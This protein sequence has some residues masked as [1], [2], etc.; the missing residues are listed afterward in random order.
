MT[1]VEGQAASP[2]GE[3]GLS[4][5]WNGDA[6]TIAVIAVII[7]NILFV[8][9]SPWFLLRRMLSP[10]V[11]VA[12]MMIA[13]IVPLPLALLLLGLATAMDVFFI[14]AFLFDMPI[15]TTFRALFYAGDIDIQVSA[16]YAAAG[17]YFILLAFGLTFLARRFRLPL[18]R[19]SPVLACCI[20][21]LIGVVDFNMN[22]YKPLSFPAFESAM[23][24][25]SLTA[26]N[27][28]ARDR[29]LLVVIVE[30]MGAFADPRE[31]SL[32]SDRLAAAAAGRFRLASGTS[33]Y[34]GSTTGAEARELCGVW[35]TY[36]EFGRGEIRDCLPEK[37]ARGGY[38]TVSY[39]ASGSALFSRRDWYPRVGIQAMNFQED[40]ERDR[41]QAIKGRCGSVFFGICDSDVGDL[42]RDDLLNAGDRRGF[43]YWLTLNSHIPY[44]PVA[45]R[46]FGCETP[47]PAISSVVPCQLAEIWSE[48]FDKVAA[49]ATD[50]NMPPVDIL[51]AGDHNT[52]LWSRD[53]YSHFLHDKVDW[54]YLEDHRPVV[55]EAAIPRAA[56]N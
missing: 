3:N 9:A 19:G 2:S 53:A 35:G 21:L 20:A 49:I 1:V 32:L 38:R 7:P 43:Y 28:L 42:V 14:I 34:Y 22:G 26:E 13:A 29:N 17:A 4:R 8:L 37:L 31:R 5:L 10:I 47:T 56:S 16:L 45:D 41:P 6:V 12:A 40:I 54:Y 44:E 46:R 23:G 25:N 27:I 36:V 11:Y 48:V 24:Q 52:P 39:H 30:G 15:D 33:N 18:R 51:I 50:P 55:G